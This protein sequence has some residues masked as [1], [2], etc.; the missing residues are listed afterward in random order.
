MLATWAVQFIGTD[1]VVGQ[2]CLPRLDRGHRK[3]LRIAGA[4]LCE[5]DVAVSRA[6][7]INKRSWTQQHPSAFDGAAIVDA[8]IR[9][10]LD[11]GV[12]SAELFC[13]NQTK[14]LNSFKLQHT[15]QTL[16]CSLITEQTEL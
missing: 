11:H 9:S 4:A 5:L 13:S 2:N 15:C 7:S 16:T 3:P 10:A 6:G 12:A 8:A 14:A 1:F